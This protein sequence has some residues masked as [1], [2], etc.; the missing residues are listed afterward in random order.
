MTARCSGGTNEKREW[1][2]KNSEHT[3]TSCV[4][5]N[6]EATTFDFN[7][8]HYK[9]LLW[10]VTTNYLSF[11]AKFNC[12]GF[13]FDDT[14]HARTFEGS[15]TLLR[16][17]TITLVHTCTIHC[18]HRARACSCTLDRAR[19]HM[20]WHSLTH[21]SHVSTFPV[22]HSLDTMTHTYRALARSLN[23]SIL[24]LGGRIGIFLYYSR[25]LQPH[26]K[27]SVAEFP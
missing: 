2:N 14:T 1:L 25:A 11:L 26:A 24:L 18:S 15:L 8:F 10:G 9:N 5:H 6:R 13:V 27:L 20:L 21:D 3:T 23:V 22:P 16:V 7:F 12:I 19:L 17:R 4:I